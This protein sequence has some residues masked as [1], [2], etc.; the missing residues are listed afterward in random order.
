MNSDPS[1]EEWLKKYQKSRRTVT[2]TDYEV[3]FIDAFTRLA[4]LASFDP[5]AYLVEREP[6]DISKLKL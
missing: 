3:D 6:V 4:S 2:R 5:D 1:Y